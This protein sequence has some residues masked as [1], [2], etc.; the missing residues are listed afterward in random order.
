[1][2]EP[3]HFIRVWDPFVRVF[4][5]ALVAAFLTAWLSGGEWLVLHVAAG[6]TVLGLV[7]LRLVWG[8]VGSR[9]A[10][11]TDFVR[12]PAAVRA[13]LR[14]VVSF[15]ARRYLGHNPAGGAMVLALLTSLLLTT[16]SGLALYGYREFSGPLAGAL[17]GASHRLGGVLQEAHEFFSHFTVL[18]VVLHLAGVALASLQ[19]GENLV[20]S[21]VSGRKQQE[22]S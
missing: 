15:R 9:H 3:V 12:G 5:W 7:S 2:P 21:M 1:M 22:S 19:H 13:Y 18:L 20:R 8:V 14:D 10:R 11:F 6:Y 17:Y 4:H 16:G